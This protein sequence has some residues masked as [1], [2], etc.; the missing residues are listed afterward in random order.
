MEAKSSSQMRYFWRFFL[1]DVCQLRSR[2]IGKFVHV[3][4]GEIIFWPNCGKLA[5]ECDSNS[6][7][8]QNV[9][10]WVFLEKQ[11]GFFFEID[12]GGK[13]AVECVSNGIIS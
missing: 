11:M 12:I 1:P 4:E 13:F 9:L 2:H 3:T 10:S 7:N 6:K 5:V 8:S